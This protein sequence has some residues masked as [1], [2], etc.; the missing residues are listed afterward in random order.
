MQFLIALNHQFF[1]DFVIF[2]IRYGKT[3]SELNYRW[4]RGGDAIGG[5]ATTP[6]FPLSWNNTE[7][8]KIQAMTKKDGTYVWISCDWV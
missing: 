1:F 8:D 2:K 7:L 3:K 4:I 5:G 6:G